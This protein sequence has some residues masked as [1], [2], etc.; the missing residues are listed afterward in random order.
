MNTPSVILQNVNVQQHGKPVLQDISFSIES[1]QHIA[2]TGHSG[3][4]KTVLAKAIAKQIFYKGNIEIN[5]VNNSS[6]QQKVVIAEHNESWK[7]LSNISDFYYQQRFNS[8]D[9]EDS[10]TVAASLNKL[11]ANNNHVEKLLLQFSLLNRSNTPLIQL[12]NGEQKKL[13]LIKILLQQSQVL[14]FDKAFTGLDITSRKVLHQI[15]NEQAANGTTIILIT[16]EKELPACITHVIELKEGRLIS[17]VEKENFIPSYK[18]HTGFSAEIPFSKAFH[19][20]NTM[21]EMKNVLVQYGE[22]KILH[23]I[24]WKVNSG[25]CW[26][27]KGHNGA[28]KSTLLSLITADNPQAYS[29]EIYLFDQRR[30]KGESIW[31]IKQKIG[32][33]SPELHKYFDTGITIEQTIASGFFDTM[34]LYKKLNAQQQKAVNDWMNYFDLNDLKNKPLS[35][36]S[37]GQQRWVLLARA[38]VKQPPLLILDEPCQGLDEQHTKQFIELIDNIF[39]QNNTTIIYISHY[40]DEIPACIQHILELKDGKQIIKKSSRKFIAA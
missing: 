25:E 39:H 7:N 8:C 9:S 35:F 22:K 10:I 20:F 40:N 1:K 15:I 23:Q 6:L 29:N 24:N 34:G 21:I 3:S 2:V 26:L 18:Y 13:Q 12:S 14:I 5:Y 16:D 37:T 36:L 32:F 28:G 38:L 17:F 30:G 11:H 33:V 4:G 19:S 31:D 27:V